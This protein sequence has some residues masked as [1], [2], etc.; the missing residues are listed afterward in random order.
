MKCPKCE[1][2]KIAEV[3]DRQGNNE[4]IETKKC[5]ICS[6]VFLTLALKITMNSEGRYESVH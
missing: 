5:C 6:C 1:S 4:Q 2:I 3:H